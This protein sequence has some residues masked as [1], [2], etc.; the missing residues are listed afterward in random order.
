MSEEKHS[1]IV[2]KYTGIPIYN[3]IYIPRELKTSLTSDNVVITGLTRITSLTPSL[4]LDANSWSHAKNGRLK[5]TICIKSGEYGP[6]MG[7][8]LKIKHN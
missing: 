6:R 7:T 1:F 5:M 8:I 4:T 2:F 3:C